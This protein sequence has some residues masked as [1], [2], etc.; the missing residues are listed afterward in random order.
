MTYISNI[1]KNLEASIS[2]WKHGY[3]LRNIIIKLKISDL[4]GNIDI[5]SPAS[6]EVSK[7]KRMFPDW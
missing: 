6:D 7:S 2:T 3:W 4:F 1:A 5:D